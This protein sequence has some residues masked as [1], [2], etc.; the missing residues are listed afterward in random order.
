MSYVKYATYCIA[1]GQKKS[2]V[3]KVLFSLKTSYWL[4]EKNPAIMND[5][6]IILL[7]SKINIQS[8]AQATK[9]SYIAILRCYLQYAFRKKEKRYERIKK[10][11]KKKPCSEVREPA[12]ILQPSDISRILYACKTQEIKTIVALMW[13]TG[14]R[15]GELLNIK[16]KD[17]MFD[18][19]GATIRL[20]GKTGLRYVRIAEVSPLLKSWASGVHFRE[21]YIFNHNYASFKKHLNNIKKQLG[22]PEMYPHLF[23]KSRATYLIKRGVPEQLVK[24]YLGWAKN[25]KMLNHYEFLT[26]AEANEAILKLADT[27]IQT[28]TTLGSF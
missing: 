7:L 28:Q 23:R 16:L 12:Y 20:D 25:S 11:I 4:C 2:R 21:Q 9:N 17:I 18:Q 5:D 24:K 27:P 10:F 3:S 1:R 26:C 8:T 22:Y 15:I 19:R 6:E 13:E 14:A